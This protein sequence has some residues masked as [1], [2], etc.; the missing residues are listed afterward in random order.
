M[1]ERRTVCSVLQYR[2]HGLT[3][4]NPQVAQWSVSYI[5]M[6]AEAKDHSRVLLYVIGRESRGITSMLEV[7]SAARES[8]IVC[9]LLPLIVFEVDIILCMCGTR[10]PIT[11]VGAVTSFCALNT[12]RTTEPW[13]ANLLVLYCLCKYLLV[14]R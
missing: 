5:P 2:S 14:F 12:C 10:W 1:V 11:L 9:I 3:Y 6:E 8:S 7:C 4:Y 13:K